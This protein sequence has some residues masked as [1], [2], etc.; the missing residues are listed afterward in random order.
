MP[1]W[2][3]GNLPEMS[4]PLNDINLI[5]EEKLVMLVWARDQTQASLGS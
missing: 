5:R 1:S 4:T 3:E 2:S